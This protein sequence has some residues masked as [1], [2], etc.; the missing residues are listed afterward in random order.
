[1]RTTW[2]RSKQDFKL[3]LLFPTQPVERCR[4]QTTKTRLNPKDWLLFK[5]RVKEVNIFVQNSP[6]LVYIFIFQ[7]LPEHV[8]PAAGFIFLL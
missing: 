3:T 4:D 5:R 2:V 6:A 7:S 8:F 1:M